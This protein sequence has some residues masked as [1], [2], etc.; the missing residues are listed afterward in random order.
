MILQLIFLAFFSTTSLHAEDK[1]ILWDSWY[2]I[3]V[4][5]NVPFSYYNET[6]EDRG[7]QIHF[8]QKMWKKEK[9]SIIEEHIGLLAKNNEELTP[10]LFNFFRS[11]GP[12]SETIIDG[13]L[14]E[15]NSLHIKMRE[16]ANI[17]TWNRQLP[18][19]TFLATFFPV[20]IAKNWAK[21]KVGKKMNFKA[22]VED[23]Y[24]TDF[25]ISPGW[26]RL[27]KEDKFSKANKTQK[28]TVHFRDASSYW[29]VKP[30]GQMIQMEMPE[31]NALVESTTE[32]KAKEFL[33]NGK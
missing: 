4:Y 6:V 28:F 11:N 2:T 24:V 7:E 17:K 15:K 1:K 30:S 8:Q 23:S 22:I 12:S 27:E 3:K 20:W 26:V 29:W 10:I 14:N 19:E 16:A 21:F 32:T 9:D 31:Q 25:P 33:K 5:D 13:T 18:K